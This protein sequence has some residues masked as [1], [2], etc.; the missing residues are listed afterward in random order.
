MIKSRQPGV[1]ADALLLQTQIFRE[2][3][4]KFIGSGPFAVL[5]RTED[6]LHLTRRVP[7]PGRVNEV[8]IASYA[9]PRDAF[10]HTL[11]GDT[12]LIVDLESKWL[13]FFRGVPSLQVVRGAGR[14]MD[15]IIFNPDLPRSERVQLAAALASARVRDL[16]YAPS[17]CAE[18][19]PG[20]AS[21]ASGCCSR[22]A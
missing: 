7:R 15:A 4:G 21:A 10:A 19:S 2:S 18:P 3:Q 5:S 1:P 11:K 12:N 16:A 6:E 13:E 22:T 9:T 8:R 14:S 20:E 17:E